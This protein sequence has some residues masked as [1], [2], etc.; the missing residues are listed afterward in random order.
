M[1]KLVLF[2][3]IFLIPVNVLA[4]SGKS[5][6]V[7]D[8][9]SGRV[10]YSKNINQKSLIAST[11]KIMTCIITLENS[12]IDDEIVVGEEILEMYGTNIY[13]KPGERIKIIDLLY[14][15]M[16]RSGNDAAQTLSY[17]TVGYDAFITK[18]N[19]K[20]KEIGMKNTS[21]SN[22]HGLDE[23]TKNYSSVYDMALLA[24]YAYGNKIYR[25][26]I[27]TRKYTTK[28]SI[29]SYTW[30]N[31]MTLLNNYKY[32][33]GGKNGYTPAA[34]KSLVSYATKGNL[35]LLIVSLDDPSIYENHT[36]LYN[37][38]FSIYK[39]YK[40]IDKDIFN[41]NDKY[42]VKNSFVYPLSI[43]E[44]DSV[45]TLLNLGNNKKEIKIMLDNEVIGRLKVYEKEQIKKENKSLF[46]KLFS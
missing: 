40:I 9:D 34:G 1:K 39:N 43:D 45:T 35:T 32:C 13:V 31:R 18:M 11:T 26:I 44:V 42:Y 20:A 21:F 16:L 23:K 33:I 19:E 36:N 27:S 22:P 10:L 28:S 17:N 25:K 41:K 29:N 2:F 37:K 46:R 15:L 4:D 30:Y 38:Y 7:M 24:R 6:I 8:V 12:N 3:I 5:T 14:G